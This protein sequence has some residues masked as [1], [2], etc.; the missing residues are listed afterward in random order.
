MTAD[1][2]IEHEPTTVPGNRPLPEGLLNAPG[3]TE[4]PGPFDGDDYMVKEILELLRLNHSEMEGM[5]RA[6]LDDGGQ[7]DRMSKDFEQKLAILRSYIAEEIIKLRD[8]ITIDRSRAD[9]DPKRVELPFSVIVVD[10][11]AEVCEAIAN[12]LEHAGITAYQSHDPEDALSI[13]AGELPI[14]VAL[15]DIRMPRNGKGLAAT[16]LEKHPRV[17]VVLMSGADGRTA[18]EALDMGA[19]A[20]IQ[21]PFRDNDELILLVSRAAEFRRMKLSSRRG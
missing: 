5:R 1:D 8:E 21:K 19:Y 20:F 13:L 12:V 14:D 2:E 4:R 9:D 7:L 17:A 16:I 6:L 10:D 11:N 3:D 15:V 18:S